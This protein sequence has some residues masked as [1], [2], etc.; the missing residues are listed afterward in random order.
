MRDFAQV[1]NLYRAPLGLT[2]L[3]Y[4]LC[5][6]PWQ[7]T[8]KDLGWVHGQPTPALA[9]YIAQEHFAVPQCL[10]ERRLSDPALANKF[11]KKFNYYLQS[12][13]YP[14][15]DPQYKAHYIDFLKRYS[16]S[17]ASASDDKKKAFCAVVDEDVQRAASN[18]V[19]LAYS[20][21]RVKARFSPV[22]EAAVHRLKTFTN[23]AVVA[24]GVLTAAASVSAAHDGLS[25][26]RA[27]NFAE[28]SQRQ[29]T[30]IQ[31]NQVGTAMMTAA[32][33]AQRA[34]LS[35]GY[36]GPPLVQEQT[37]SD[38]ALKVIMC[39]VLTHFGRHGEPP[40]SQIWVTY[41]P[42]SIACRDATMS[43]VIAKG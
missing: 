11:L 1:H 31:Y 21:S 30:A 25:A 35:S 33:G 18:F 14:R 27:G 9:M 42:V 24:G 5:L 22:S 8:A 28:A 43:D 17:W 26:A 16:D 7:A 15:K 40:A 3:F 6:M 4:A 38:G 36:P 23:V 32:A 39:P 29:G 37:G 2:A 12:N 41:Q 13:A 19:E 10:A 34:P 20:V